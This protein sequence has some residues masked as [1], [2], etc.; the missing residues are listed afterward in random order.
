LQKL[1]EGGE[2]MESQRDTAQAPEK[3]DKEK[4]V[5][6]QIYTPT[7]TCTGYVY[8]SH[9]RRLL[10]VL[11][12]IPFRVPSDRDEFLPVSEAE[13]RSPDGKEETVQICTH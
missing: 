6:V 12:G 11:N 5:K 2:A 3:A 13:I 9:R 8:C 4:W 7:Q 10:D 1:K